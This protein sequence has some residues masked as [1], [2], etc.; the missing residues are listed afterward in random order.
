MGDYIF[1]GVIF[2]IVAGMGYLVGNSK[3]NGDIFY[4]CATEEVFMTLNGAKIK[5]E[6]I[7][8]DAKVH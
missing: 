1:W 8:S 2:F 7:K 6:I 4:K 5:C 3:M